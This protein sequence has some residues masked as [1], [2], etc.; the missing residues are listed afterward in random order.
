LQQTVNGTAT[1][2]TLDLATGLTQ[3]LADTAKVYV[4]GNGRIAQQGL[5]TEYFLTDA[6]GSVQQLTDAAGNVTLAQSYEPFGET[7]SSAGSGSTVWQFAGEARDASGLTFLRSRYL[8]TAT[9]R[10]FNRDPWAGPSV[11]Q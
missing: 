4:Y 11:S 1:N 9:G 2:Y 6:L 10:F 5:T 8:N 7:L 3:V